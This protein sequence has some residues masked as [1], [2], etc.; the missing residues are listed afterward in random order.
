MI[1]LLTHPDLRRS[2]RVHALLEFLRDVFAERADLL[3]GNLDAQPA[4]P[5]D[6][7]AIG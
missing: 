4:A 1:W 7:V 2:R 5:V 6:A 3:L